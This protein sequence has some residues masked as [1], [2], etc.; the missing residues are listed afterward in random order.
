MEKLVPQKISISRIFHMLMEIIFPKYGGWG[1]YFSKIRE[2][3]EKNSSKCNVVSWEEEKIFKQ[4]LVFSRWRK[5][6]AQS[7]PAGV[8]SRDSRR[9][10]ALRL[11][12][13]QRHLPRQI[14]Y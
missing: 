8:L 2:I 9:S 4:V 7:K 6:L 3:K 13:P 11:S 12:L 14:H 1:S 5:Q 10:A